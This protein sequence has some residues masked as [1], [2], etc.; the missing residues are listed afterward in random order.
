MDSDDRGARVLSETDRER[1]HRIG[2]VEHLKR[3]LAGKSIRGSV[4]IAVSEVVCSIFRLAGTVMLARLLMPEHFGL[5]S[6]VTALTAFVEMFKDL[7]LGTATIRESEITHDQVSTLFWINAAV[8]TLIMVLIAG[9][10]P[11]ISLFYGD[12][13]VLWVSIAVSSSFFFG[14]LTIQHQ[15]LLLRHMYFTR[16]ASIQVF[17]TG[18][19]FALG[20][21]FAWQGF[22]YWA[23]VWK[24]VSRVVVQAIG[25]WLLARWLPGLPKRGSGI[26]TLLRTGKYLT[27]FNIVVFLSR[28]LDQILLGRFWGPA[29]VGLYKQPAQLL[30]LPGSLFS[31][32]LTYIM[33]PAL[34]ALQN[35]PERYREYYRRAV[36]FLCFCYMPTIAYLAVYSEN[37]V[38]L[39]LGEQWI[40]SAPVLRILAF[41]AFVEPIIQT[42]GI[43]MVTYGRTRAYFR[44]GV[45]S[46]TSLAF[47]VC[48]GVN[49]GLSGVATA[50]VI[51]T[52]LILVP[53]LWFSFKET[54][55]SISLCLDSVS[56]S[57]LSSV[58]MSL[59]LSMTGY[60]FRPSNALAEIGISLLLA[61]L[62]YFGVWMLLPRGRQRLL[63]HLSYVRLALEGLPLWT[64]SPRA[65]AKTSSCV[66]E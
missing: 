47:A 62:L 58:V 20:V 52:Y 53:L 22:E 11:L 2:D 8:G 3:D 65:R 59:L 19:S 39:V 55:I 33:T 28:N 23:L 5:I 6:M 15:A 57:A 38:T 44:W 30:L 27:G 16:V 17:S 46:S 49:W 48:V 18:L 1:N 37:I 54:P 35:S 60:T 32:P 36:S 31:F 41:A 10:S 61:P 4:S 66:I 64:R 40:A 26:G 12:S 13:R 25:V 21:F 7:G 63:E 43:V 42:C 14:G 29:P 9:A 56:L 50:I 51:Y 24:E 45:I 34:S